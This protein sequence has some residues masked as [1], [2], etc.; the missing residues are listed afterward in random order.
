MT[1]SL[2]RVPRTHDPVAAH[3]DRLDARIDHSPLENWAPDKLC[4]LP[5]TGSPDYLPGTI[6]FFAAAAEQHVGVGDVAFTVVQASGFTA[7]VRARIQEFTAGKD[8][9]CVTLTE[10]PA[11]NFALRGFTDDLWEDLDGSRCK[12]TWAV[13][14]FRE[15]EDVWAH[16]RIPGA[17][18]PLYVGK[19]APDPATAGRAVET[20]THT[21]LVCHPYDPHVSQIFSAEFSECIE[22]ENDATGSSEEF[23][24]TILNLW[25][26][27]EHDAGLGSVVGERSAQENSAGRARLLYLSVD[28]V[29]VRDVVLALAVAKP[30]EIASVY[31][32]VAH[33]T[34]GEA[35]ANAMS[36]CAVAA[37]HMGTAD[38]A[39]GLLEEVRRALPDHSLSALLVALLEQGSEDSIGRA[40][41]HAYDYICERF[42]VSEEVCRLLEQQ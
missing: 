3:F 23:G 29:L 36:I 32:E 12:G 13:A 27:I 11:T 9:A 26:L 20:L 42:A 2:N 33:A 35:W 8:W 41:T 30:E 24:D 19:I 4:A 15:N 34:E 6:V 21:A 10:C 18:H 37:I 17:G 16:P 28:N 5:A 14:A 40:V 22:L 39:Y 31:L 7:D 38:Y 1:H 25:N